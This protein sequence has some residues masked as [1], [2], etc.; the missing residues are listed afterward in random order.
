MLEV[1]GFQPFSTT[2]WPGRLAAVV[3]VQGCPWRCSYCHNPALQPRARGDAAQWDW[4]AVRRVLEHRRG[5][6]DG[7]VFSGGEPTL[8]PYLPQAIDDA[9]ALGFGIGLHTAGIYA[10]WLAELLPR[11]D[12]IGLDLK[13]SAAGYDELTGARGSAR[14]AQRALELVARSGVPC[15]VRTTYSAGLQRPADLRDMAR[16]LRE[17]GVTHWVLQRKRAAAGEG[18][19]TEA[20][21]AADLLEGLT[22][23]GLQIELR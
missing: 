3:F 6:L 16:Q 22:A 15:E 20:A 14:A 10:K 2:D 19:R 23:E 17:A 4:L 11:L 5:L 1:G 9:R 21:P 8:D 18:W 12:W 13:A 7:V